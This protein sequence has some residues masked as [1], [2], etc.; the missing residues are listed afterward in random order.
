MLFGRGKKGEKKI[1]SLFDEHLNII[2]NC[3]DKLKELTVNY[4]DDS[5]V[6]KENAFD[7]HK[8]EGR[9]DDIRRDI[10]K[11]IHAGAFFP[12]LREDYINL[13]ERIDKIADRAESVSDFYVLVNP[14]IPK[15]L[16]GAI[17]EITE[18]SIAAYPRFK[19]ILGLL[20]FDMT[21]VLS[22]AAQINAVEGKVDKLE[23]DL[24]KRIFR[25]EIDLSHKLVL[26]E[27]VWS[28]AN[29]SDRIQ[30]ASDRIEI[31]VAKH[32]V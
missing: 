25:L 28:I 20:H 18:N 9:A 15:Q 10:E 11:E 31:M 30:D 5:I 2:E 32:K 22:K 6:Y 29:I 27:L 19:E 3:L 24:M 4:I 23:W 26:R 17:K 14:V 16:H 12:F 8:L 7:V 21:Q 1:R 13:A